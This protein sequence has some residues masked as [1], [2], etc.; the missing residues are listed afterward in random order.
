MF[1][2]PQQEEIDLYLQ[3][4]VDLGHKYGSFAFYNYHWSFAARDAAKLSQF[5]ASTNWSILDTELFCC[6][7]ACLCSPLCSI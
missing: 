1:S 5:Q 6:Y 7:F 3:A 2:K 4:S